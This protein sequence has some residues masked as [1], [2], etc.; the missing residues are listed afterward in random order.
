LLGLSEKRCRS[1]SQIAGTRFVCDCLFT[2]TTY[3]LGEISGWKMKVVY[4]T[5]LPHYPLLEA[6]SRPRPEQCAAENQNSS[7]FFAN[8]ATT[9]EH[10]A[11]LIGDYGWADTGCYGSTF[12]HTPNIDRLAARGMRF[13]EAYPAAPVCSS[14]RAAL[15]TGKHPA[16]LHLIDWLPGRADRPDQKLARPRIEQQ[17]QLSETTLAEALKQ[18]GYAMAQIGK[19]HLGGAGFEPDAAAHGPA[20]IQARGALLALSTL[21][22]LGRQAWRCGRAISS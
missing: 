9:A 19:W 21:Q 17:L 11:V 12:H 6:V 8:S 20:A 18:V 10:R 15:M 5:P 4:P 22:Q 13:T 16:R 2:I 14:T 3:Q 7:S 1:Q